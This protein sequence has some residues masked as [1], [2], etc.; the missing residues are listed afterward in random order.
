VLIIYL[1]ILI[2]TLLCAFEFAPADAVE[3]D[4]YHLAGNTIKS[5][6]RGREHEGVQLPLRIRRVGRR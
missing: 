3:I 2:S 5:K 6:V 4:F 1:Q